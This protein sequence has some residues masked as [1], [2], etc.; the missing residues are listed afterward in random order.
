MDK[1]NPSAYITDT[2]PVNEAVMDSSGWYEWQF[3]DLGSGDHSEK[4]PWLIAQG[5]TIAYAS[6]SGGV[7]TYCVLRR[8]VLKPETALKD[9]ITSFTN[10]Y[11]E[12]RTLN[13]QRY[14][15]I[16]ALYTVMLD[17]TEDSLNSLQSSDTT[18]DALIENLLADVKTDYD[19]HKDEMDGLFDDYGDAQRTRIAT[20]F[21][22]QVAESR[23]SMIARGLYNTT[24]WDSLYA[25]VERERARALTDLE[26]KILERQAALADRLFALKDNMRGKILAARDRLRS[27]MQ[28]LDVQRVGL[29]N[30]V[31]QAMLG[32]MERREDGYPDLSNIG[33]LASNLGASQP[34]YPAP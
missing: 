5:W 16:V 19:D 29:R 23:A 12:G 4:L 24:T 11:N 22:N 21:D 1:I 9:L 17:K 27:H 18:Y 34:T 28:D 25:G 33:Q 31:L 10:A 26:D 13:D 32:F 15:E 20:Q 7:Y 3:L 8:R 14:D 6:E 2:D 30:T